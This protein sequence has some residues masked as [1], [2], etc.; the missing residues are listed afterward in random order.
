MA[1]S[2]ARVL[3]FGHV[4]YANVDK[5]SFL[6]DCDVSPETAAINLVQSPAKAKFCRHPWTKFD[7]E[8]R[9]CFYPIE[10]INFKGAPRSNQPPKLLPLQHIQKDHY[11]LL[12]SSFDS[13]FEREFL[14]LFETRSGAVNLM[15]SAGIVDLRFAFADSAPRFESL[16]DDGPGPVSLALYCQTLDPVRAAQPSNDNFNGEVTTSSGRFEFF[17][18]RLQEV[19]IECLRR[20]SK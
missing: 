1:Q 7:L 14:S 4:T 17:M 3:T 20:I 5:R 12:S 2:K 11:A 13:N 10:T 19:W 6:Q 9:R 16:L 8:V 18:F 15:K